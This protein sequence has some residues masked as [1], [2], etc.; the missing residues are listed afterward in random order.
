MMNIFTVNFKQF[1]AS[2]LNKIKNIVQTPISLTFDTWLWSGT[3]TSSETL[4]ETHM[5]LLGSREETEWY[6]I[7]IVCFFPFLQSNTFIYLSKELISK[8]QITTFLTVYK[9][10]VFSNPGL[11]EIKACKYISAVLLLRTVSYW[12]VQWVAVKMWLQYVTLAHFCYVD[13]RHVL[14]FVYYVASGTYHGL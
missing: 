9:N 5:S 10:H 1:N 12:N 8:K 13:I 7:C 3:W 11:F 2:L 4:E 6:V 14:L